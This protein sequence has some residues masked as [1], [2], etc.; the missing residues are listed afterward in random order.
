[1]SDIL[2]L[3]AEALARDTHAIRTPSPRHNIAPSTAADDTGKIHDDYLGI[4][5]SDASDTRSISSS[6]VNYGPEGRLRK[7]LP[8]VPDLRFEQ[9]YLASIAPAQ[10]VWWKIVL[11]TLKDQVMMPLVQGV[12]YNLLVTGWRMWN[13]GARLSGAGVGGRWFFAQRG[14]ERETDE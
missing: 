14:G 2:P 12:L 9:S 10:G 5:D 13:R 7:Q 4:D 11:I 1:M 8:Q 3:V 6:V